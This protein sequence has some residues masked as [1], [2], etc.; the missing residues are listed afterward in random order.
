MLVLEFKYHQ[1]SKCLQIQSQNMQ[2]GVCAAAATS[3]SFIPRPEC[4]P[5]LTLR[6]PCAH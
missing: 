2:M 5:Y 6:P 1:G 3:I 4:G